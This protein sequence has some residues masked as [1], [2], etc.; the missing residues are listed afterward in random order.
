[1]V[2]ATI[3]STL[4]TYLTVMCVD[5]RAITSK[6]LTVEFLQSNNT[7][8]NGPNQIKQGVITSEMRFTAP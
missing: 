3:F 8:I 1:M 2:F 4:V 7:S 6:S 5:V